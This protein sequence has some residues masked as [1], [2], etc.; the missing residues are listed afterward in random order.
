M[1]SRVVTVKGP[2]GILT[3]SFRHVQVDMQM[4]KKRKLRVD[5]WFGSRKELAAV[6]T[7]CTHVEN[8][9]RGV[10]KVENLAEIFNLHS[11]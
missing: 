6:R 2:R 1:R 10:T 4:I 9:I 11:N 5:K 3:R 8:M 7:V